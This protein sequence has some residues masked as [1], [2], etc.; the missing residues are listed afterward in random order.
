MDENTPQ[1]YIARAE[2][3]LNEELPISDPVLRGLYT[4]LVLTTGVNT[5]LEDVHDAWA[6]WRHGVKPDSWS[7]VPFD[8]LTSKRQEKD[9]PY[10]RAIRRAAA[11]L[12]S[13]E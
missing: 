7:L 1:S 12:E 6:I 13:G 8:D 11:R 3:A 2:Q 10:R 4:L 5:T 9:R